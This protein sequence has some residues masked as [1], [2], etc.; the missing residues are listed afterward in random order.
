MDTPSEPENANHAYSTLGNGSEAIPFSD[1][2]VY[3]NHNSCEYS[4]ACY[5][6]NDH[7]RSQVSDALFGICIGSPGI[8]GSDHQR[9]DHDYQNDK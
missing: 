6:L 2:N 3:A 7:D 9:Y 8:Y 4:Y 1:S 5:S